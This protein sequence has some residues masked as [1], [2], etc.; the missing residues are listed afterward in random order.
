[1]T[2]FQMPSTLLNL[3]MICII[4]VAAG[5][6]LFLL[7]FLLWKVTDKKNKKRNILPHLAT[8]T[9]SLGITAIIGTSTYGVYHN[10]ETMMQT[11]SDTYHVKVLTLENW[12]LTVVKDT[13]VQTCEIRTSSPD[14]YVVQCEIPHQGWVNL[15]SIQ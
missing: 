12:D 15:E 13:K 5:V 2:S 8:I 11:V 14:T 3:E 7:F 9:S 6:F 4:T 10:T 1:M